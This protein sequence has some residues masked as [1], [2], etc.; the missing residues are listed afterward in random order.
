VKKLVLVSALVA[1]TAAP[2][3]GAERLTIQVTS[4]A[5]S[6]KP[7]DVAPKGTS[8]GDTIEY[9]DRLVNVEARFGRAKGAVVGSDHGTMTFTGKHSAVFAGIAR[10]P[11]GTLRLTGKVIALP[12]H[13]FAI[14]VN[15]GTG[16]FAKAKGYVLVG[17]GEKTALNTYTLTL[18]T[19]PVA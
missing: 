7:T 14:P 19:V 16:R 5:L 2:S 4:V 12:N 17:P 1:A 13:S 8:K 11:G 10:L 9:R 18:P 3:A 15:G 6:V